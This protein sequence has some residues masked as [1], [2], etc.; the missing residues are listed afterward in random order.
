ME[1]EKYLREMYQD[2]YYPK[3]LVDKIK[4]LLKEVEAVLASGEK[5]LAVIQAA[6]DKATL[7]I[8]DLES[9]FNENDSEIET[10][11]RDDIGETV[12]ALLDAYQID[13]DVEDAIR[14][15]EW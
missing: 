3:F 8:N 13:L 1:E 11:A 7:A 14:E 2:D 4:V 10:V 9:E 12:G 5:D 6:F 15:R